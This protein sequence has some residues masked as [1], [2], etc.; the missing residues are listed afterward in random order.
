[1]SEPEV[2]A[3]VTPGAP[4]P[5]LVSVAPVLLFDLGLAGFLHSYDN[6]RVTG[7]LTPDR[8]SW[9]YQQADGFT[10]LPDRDETK[11]AYARICLEGNTI[12]AWEPLSG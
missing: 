1:M 12:V 9:V 4:V 11:P 8:W 10:V 3:I 6:G 2:K 5:T 7:A